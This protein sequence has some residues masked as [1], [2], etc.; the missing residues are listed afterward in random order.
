MSAIPISSKL[1][2]AVPASRPAAAGRLIGVSC[3]SATACSAVGWYVNGSGAT[4]PLGEGSAR[5]R[6]WTIQNIPNPSVCWA[7]CRAPL[8]RVCIAVGAQDPTSASGGTL[9]ELSV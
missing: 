7:P 5:S 9:A 4:L 8:P 6:S 1:V 2:L 3:V